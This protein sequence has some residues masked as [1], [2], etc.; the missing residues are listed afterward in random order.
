M[1]LV[2]LE[3]HGER[4]GLVIDSSKVW[5]SIAEELTAQLADHRI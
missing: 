4:E 1:A 5:R 3:K 2:F